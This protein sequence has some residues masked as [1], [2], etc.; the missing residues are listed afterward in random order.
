V[1]EGEWRKRNKG[2]GRERWEAGEENEDEG[3]KK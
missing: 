3:D 1:Y 2:E